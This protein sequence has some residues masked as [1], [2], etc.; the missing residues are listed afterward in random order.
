MWDFLLPNP[1]DSHYDQIT[2]GH[3]RFLTAYIPLDD[4]DSLISFP[5]HSQ[6]KKACSP[7]AFSVALKPRSALL[8]FNMLPNGNLDSKTLHQHCEGQGLTLTI[9][10][11]NLAIHS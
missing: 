11:W 3:N 9:R 7:E 5:K 10:L 8:I 2:R 1:L 6:G 4:Q